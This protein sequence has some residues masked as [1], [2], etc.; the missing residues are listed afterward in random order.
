MARKTG[1]ELVERS[2]GNA[3][4]AYGRKL[5]NRARAVVH[6]ALDRLVSGDLSRLV[7]THGRTFRDQ[8][9]HEMLEAPLGSMMRIDAATPSDEGEE[10][11]GPAAQGVT[12]IAALYLVAMQGA[13]KAAEPKVIEGTIGVQ[14]PASDW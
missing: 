10:A 13:N 5:N 6:D 1:S 2:G 7:G 12:N 14:P 9:A 4:T 8:L 3:I 11:K